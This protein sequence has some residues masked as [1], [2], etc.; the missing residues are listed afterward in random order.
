M[1]NQTWADIENVKLN[2]RPQ[3]MTI[4]PNGHNFTANVNNTA[5]DRAERMAPA[6]LLP[7][8][9]ALAPGISTFMNRLIAPL[10]QGVAQRPSTSTYKDELTQKFTSRALQ[11]TRFQDTKALEAFEHNIAQKQYGMLTGFLGIINKGYLW[12]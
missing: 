5:K 6:A 9:A 8:V 2:E 3:N 1:Y 12:A 7:I 4:L 11:G 10:I